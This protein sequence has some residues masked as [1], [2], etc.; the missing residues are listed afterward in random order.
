MVTSVWSEKRFRPWTIKVIKTESIFLIS[1][2]N[3]FANIFYCILIKICENSKIFDAYQ[4][5]T[6]LKVAKFLKKSTIIDGKLHWYI[7]NIMR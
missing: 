7:E 2:T 3:F 6:K 1:V 4:I 5:V